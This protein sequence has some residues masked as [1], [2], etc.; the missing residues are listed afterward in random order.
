MVVPG[1]LALTAL[2]LRTSS[3]VEYFLYAMGTSLAFLILG[4]L[5]INDALPVL[6][7]TAPL[8]IVPLVGAFWIGMSIL[9]G[10]VLWRCRSQRFHIT[11]RRP[12]S[13]QFIMVL[14]S[15]LL[16]LMSIGGA[17]ILNNH[18]SGAVSI[19]MLFGI[20]V[21]IIVTVLLRK[22]F[23]TSGY[24]ISIFT[25]SLSLLF[26]YSLRSWHILGWD[27]HQEFA[28]FQATYRNHRWRM[29]YFPHQPYN[30]C[31]S[32]TILP[33]IVQL[34]THLSGEYVFKLADQLIFAVVPVAVFG[35]ARRYMEQSLAFLAALAFSSQ[36]WFYEQMPALI[37]QE[38]AFV[39]FVLL[40]LVIFDKVIS[41]RVSVALFYTFTA[42]L[43]LSHYSTAYVWVILLL[44]GYGASQIARLVYPSFRG[45]HGGFTLRRFG[46][47]LLILLLWQGGVTHT[48]N[49]AANFATG[50]VGDLG[51]AMSAKAIQNGVKIAF[52]GSP[53]ESTNGNLRVVYDL[54][55][56]GLGPG[57]ND[58]YPASS[59]R[60]FVLAAVDDRKYLSSHVPGLVAS[61]VRLL[62]VAG[63]ATLTNIFTLVG[64]YVIFARLRRRRPIADLD[65]GI[66]CLASCALIV[67][68]LIVPYFQVQYGL[69]RLYLQTFVP[70]SVA[71][72]IGMWSVFRHMGQVRY[73][74]ASFLVALSLVFLTG[75]MDHVIGGPMRLTTIQ[76]NGNFD[77]FY[78]YDQE[79]ASAKWLAQNRNVTDP[80]YADCIASLRLQSYA[81]ITANPDVFP[82]CITRD[83]YVYLDLANVKRGHA[84]YSYNNTT[85]AAKEP[86][87]FLNAQKDI[88]YSNGDSTIYH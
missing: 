20:A 7:V 53:F 72:V 36:T 24:A 9:G 8:S 84:F 21:Y 50:S 75:A 38:V 73:L 49:T 32:I 28:V 6:G 87:A 3:S 31:L 56:K 17:N 22:H 62:E 1:L 86:T 80:V 23:T 27:I 33:T 59:Y 57:S 12:D 79:V 74:A 51:Q 46:V 10:I 35:I 43:V 40:I 88:I 81:N 61:G 60:G 58:L 16:L 42:A 71:A 83:G 30:S 66:L 67:A 29:S 41:K 65:Y 63:K 11:T 82:S 39:S 45:E 70:L 2:R 37:R 85:I 47:S 68:F 48:V 4:G 5:V 18:G 34:F 76:P 77:T 19:T 52:S 54:A 14:V 13:V 25:L 64:T 26:M 15:F 78:V 55:V 69:T 44:L